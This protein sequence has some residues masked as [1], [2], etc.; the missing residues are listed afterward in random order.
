MKNLILIITLLLTSCTKVYQEIWAIERYPI[1]WEEEIVIDGDHFHFE[2]D[3]CK[4]KC[5]YY[6]RDTFCWN[7][8]DTIIVRK[9]EKT[10]RVK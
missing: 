6:E 3:D 9:L 1:E 2:D 7:H 10:I 4:W 5:F 8:H